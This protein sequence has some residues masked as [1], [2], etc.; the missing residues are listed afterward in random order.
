[1]SIPA[2]PSLVLGMLIDLDKIKILQEISSAQQPAIMAQDGLNALT[3]SM[4]KLEAVERQL[5]NMSAPMTTLLEMG[6][7][8]QEMKASIAMAAMT[9][10]KAVIES[11]KQ[12]QAIKT[13]AVG[14]KKGGQISMAAESPID[15][16][17]S[18]VS[19][20]PFAY[21]SI[22]MDVQYFRQEGYDSSSHADTVSSFVQNSLSDWGGSNEQV[23][24][25][26]NT[27]HKATQRQSENHKLEGTIVIIASCTHKNATIIDPCVLD[28]DK[29]VKAWNFHNSK[30]SID[31]SNS[32]L[33]FAEVKKKDR[34]TGGNKALHI[35]SGCTRGSSFVGFV[36]I[37]K[38]ETSSSKESESSS[39]ST[40]KT[41]TKPKKKEDPE[42]VAAD[43]KARAEEELYVAGLTGSFQTKM[44]KQSSSSSEVNCHCSLSCM[45][46]IPSITA[47]EM[48]TTVKMMKPDSSEIMN[49]LKTLQ[50]QAAPSGGGGKGKRGGGGGDMSTV[51]A[52]ARM[53]AQF[54]ELSNS[55]VT[56]SMKSMSEVSTEKNKII[57][58]N[59]L[60]T[61]FE[62]YLKKASSAEV[63]FGVPINF[64]IKQL[65]K[66]DI[67]KCYIQKYYPNGPDESGEKGK[68]KQAA[69][70]P[71]VEEQPAVEE[72]EQ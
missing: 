57:D 53:G 56:N 35:L 22:K 44:N 26:G 3:L 59:T 31:S 72:E 13:Q 17:L 70:A 11:E 14:K 15:F 5:I 2:D 52:S 64:Y 1:M 38:T 42:A 46:L 20:F 28:P 6:V 45:G 18:K 8:K 19:N 41:E 48:N 58:I 47:S 36:H 71:A 25:Q 27:A 50:N 66:K 60:M 4:Y 9:Y 34:R 37:T 65:T 24:E 29:A 40:N 67:C 12:I 51:G 61:A 33:L 16:T 21:D 62:D 69:P 10:A 39:S 32:D 63:A 30:N 23:S 68:G 49:S 54:M 55:F 43:I 7:F